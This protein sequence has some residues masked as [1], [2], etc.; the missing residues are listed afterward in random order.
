MTSPID[1]TEM[2]HVGIMV[3]D[4]EEAKARFAA[5]GGYRWNETKT[6]NLLVRLGDG[7]EYMQQM[8]YVYS[9]DAPHVELVQEVP[10]TPWSAAPNVATHHIG[11]L[12]DD[13]ATTIK[14]LTETGFTLEV[15][16]VI[17]GAPAL[18]AYLLDPVGIRIEIVD[19]TIV[20]EYLRAAVARSR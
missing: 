10:G 1:A 13:V 20:P 19:R 6:G 16:A 9:Q 2:Y 3:P 14:R 12:C 17:D 15:C 11:Y 8:Q 4:I 18:F 5:A 7:T